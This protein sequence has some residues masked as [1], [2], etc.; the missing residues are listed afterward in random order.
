MHAPPMQVAVVRPLLGLPFGELRDLACV[1]IATEAHTAAVAKDEG[2]VEGFVPTTQEAQVITP[3]SGVAIV[4]P[5]ATVS[6]VIG[7]VTAARPIRHTV[8]RIGEPTVTQTGAD[9]KVT[10]SADVGML[11]AE[12]LKDS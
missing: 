8:R 10:T 5:S 11:G 3:E 4:T 12:S 9:T 2:N 7:R 1:F 6:K